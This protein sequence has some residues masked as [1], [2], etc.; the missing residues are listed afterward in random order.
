MG[1]LLRTNCRRNKVNEGGVD[2]ITGRV[3]DMPM[4][5][6]DEGG[7]GLVEVLAGAVHIL[8][9]CELQQLR[10]GDGKVGEDCRDERVPP[11][12]LRR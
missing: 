4:A 5:R 7:G 12:W 1:M 10:C 8:T 6:A 3:D 11:L 2:V 9:A